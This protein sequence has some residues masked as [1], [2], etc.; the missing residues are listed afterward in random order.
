MNQHTA[1][2]PNGSDPHRHSSR[3]RPIKAWCLRAAQELVI[4]TARPYTLRELPGWGKIYRAL[5]GH[6]RGWFWE[7]APIRTTRGK[8]HHHLMRLDLSKWPDRWAYFLGRWY[9]LETQLLVSDLLGPGD[10]VIDV[11]ANRGMFTLLA[12]RLVGDAGQVIAFE[13]NP[14]CVHILEDELAANNIRNVVVHVLEDLRVKPAR[15][16]LI[17]P[18]EAVN[19]KAIQAVQLVMQMFFL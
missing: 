12:S 1:L 14:T 5:V 3:P 10:T 19:V 2:I 8:L 17:T 11:G 9:D 7:G 18:R 16:A 6:R 4:A 13:P 15:Q